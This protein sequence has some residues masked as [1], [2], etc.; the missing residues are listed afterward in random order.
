MS[1]FF[2][3]VS[4][5]LLL[6]ALIAGAAAD[7]LG[8]P[9]VYWATS[10]YSQS[11]F[12]LTFDRSPSEEML[13]DAV[14]YKEPLIQEKYEATQ[15]WR[16]VQSEGSRLY[17]KL[18]NNR[19][20]VISPYSSDREADVVFP[21]GGRVMGIWLTEPRTRLHFPALL[22]R[23]SYFLGAFFGTVLVALLFQWLWYFSLARLRELSQAIR[24]D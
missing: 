8:K 17:I 15:Q 14:I 4:G 3:I 16:K 21:T 7:F 9:Y 22:V 11:S 13:L 18:D 20:V 12:L 6:V 1:R 10:G 5:P 19:S 24:G 23:A 2:K